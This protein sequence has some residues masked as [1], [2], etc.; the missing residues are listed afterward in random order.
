MLYL[1]ISRCNSLT[2]TCQYEKSR[3][4]Y[5]N[6]KKPPVMPRGVESVKK[7]K[8]KS[9]KLVFPKMEAGSLKTSR[10]GR[11]GHHALIHL[12]QQF[13]SPFNPPLQH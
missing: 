12:E 4:L 6:T 2:V 5:K 11:F 10:R 3:K 1:F 9:L 8:K 13:T 7:K